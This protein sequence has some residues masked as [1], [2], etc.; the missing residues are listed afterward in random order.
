MWGSLP[1]AHQGRCR[2][3]G[4][5]LRRRHRQRTTRSPSALRPALLRRQCARPRR[6]QPRIRLQELAALTMPTTDDLRSHRIHRPPHRRTRRRSPT[7]SRPRRTKPHSPG[8]TGPRTRFRAPNI[9]LHDN[10]ATDA[11][12]SDITVVLNCAGPFMRTATPLMEAAIRTHTHYLDVAAELDSYHLAEHS[13]R[14]PATPESC[15]FPEAAAASPCSAVWPATPHNASRTPSTCT[16]R[17]TSPGRCPEDQPSAP[18]RISPPTAY[19][20][21]TVNS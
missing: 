11:A 19:N 18:P 15:Y 3:R 16:S 21:S 7:R 1:T 13:T 6:L 14:P 9:D 2:L 4:R 5:P 10:E 17:C 8:S 12:L 20:V